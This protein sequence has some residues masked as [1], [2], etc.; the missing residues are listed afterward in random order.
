MLT[1][2]KAAKQSLG[3]ANYSRVFVSAHSCLLFKILTSVH[4]MLFLFKQSYLRK[5]T[6]K[7]LVE[8]RK[9][10]FMFTGSKSSDNA[11]FCVSI[12][13]SV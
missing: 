11:I 10:Y 1:E 2:E 6:T 5:K 12:Q 7:G 3:D 13:Y 4:Q 9:K 8:K